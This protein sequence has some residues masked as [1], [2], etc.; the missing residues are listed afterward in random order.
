MYKLVLVR[1]GES[2]WNMKEV[3]RFTGWT[4]VGLS[5]RG[6]QEAKNSAKLLTESGYTFDVAYTSVLKRA[7]K[8]LWIILEDMDLMWI[9]VHNHWR[10]NERH[11]GALQGLNKKETAE[12][13]GDEQVH[14]WRRSYDIPPPPLDVSDPR[15]PGLDPRYADLSEAEIPRCESLQDTVARMLPYW[16]ETIAPVVR[17]GQRVLVAAHGN[18]LRALVKYLDRVSDQ[19]IPELN[20]PTGQPLVYELDDQLKPIRS[21]YLDPQAAAEAAAAVAAQSKR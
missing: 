5:D 16:H 11:Y 17:S 12:L 6:V 10:L 9:P 18:S 19:D 2:T 4:D 7:I 1:H 13:H 14:V 8:T 20:I 15:Y 21:Y 3:N